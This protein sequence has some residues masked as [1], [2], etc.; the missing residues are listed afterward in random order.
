MPMQG[1]VKF[2]TGPW[3][4]SFDGIWA[5]SPWNARIRIATVHQFSPMNGIDWEANAALIKAAPAMFEALQAIIDWANFALE[6]PQA[7]DSH[8]VRNLDG[9]AFDRARAA[10]ALATGQTS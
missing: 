10:I 6:N 7:F 9:P 4:R 3:E 2:T 5:V 8:G 1:E